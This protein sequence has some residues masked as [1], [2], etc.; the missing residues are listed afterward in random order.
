MT[1]TASQ[2]TKL[3]VLL[4][5]DQLSIAQNIAQ[6]MEAKGHVFD[7]ATN[8]KQGLELALEQ[9][10]DLVILDLNLPGMDGLEICQQLRE[11]SSRH[12]PI[13]MLTARDSIDDKVTGFGVGADDYLTKPFVLQELEVRC[14]ALSR[15]HLLQTNNTLVLGPLSIDRKSKQVKRDEQVL[16]LHAMGVRIVTIL[17]EAYPQVVSRS[18]LTQKLWGDEPTESDAMRS[19]IYQLRNVLDKPFDKPLLKTVHGV[20][21]VLDINNDK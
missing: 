4:V 15:R 20:G 12:I 21:F 1:N 9:P 13:L 17:A 8:G 7:F 5:E 3:N 6:Y 2:Q 19:H 16:D 18:E 14:L 10:Y 11:K